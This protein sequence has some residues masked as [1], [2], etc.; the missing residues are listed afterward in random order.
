[1]GKISSYQADTSL[2]D[3]DYLIGNQASPVATKIFTLSSI[4]S[5][6]AG[7]VPLGWQNINATLAYSSWDSTNKTGVMTTTTDLSSVISIGMK[8]SITQSGTTKY[9]FVTAIGSAT[10]TGYFGTDYT[11]TNA[12]I[13]SPVYSGLSSP[14]GFPKDPA[15]WTASTIATSAASAAQTQNVWSNLGSN[16]ITLPIG[17]WKVDYSSSVEATR[18]STGTEAN[19]TLSTANNSES[20]INNTV[21]QAITATGSTASDN[22]YHLAKYNIPIT[23]AVATTYFLNYRTRQ[24]STTFT[25]AGGL[26]PQIIRATCAYL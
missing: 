5:Y 12:T 26:T 23:V 9:F 15:K 3:S 18:A 20:D 10:I 2:Q 16:S 17:A 24:T 25:L 4:A 1:M 19:S 22:T 13:S 11:L 21:T 14:Y 7:K 6:V 8:G